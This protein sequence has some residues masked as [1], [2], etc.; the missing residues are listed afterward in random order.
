LSGVCEGVGVCV[1]DLA[2]D[3][4]SPPTIVS[5]AASNQADVNLCHSNSLSVVERFD[6]GEEVG[7]LLNEIG[8]VD[9]QL[10]AVLWG[11]LSPDCP[12]CLSGS[13]YRDIDI[14]LC[15][16]V[17]GCDNLLGGWVDRLEGLAVDTLNKLVV[18]EPVQGRLS[19]VLPRHSGMRGNNVGETYNPVGCSYLPVDGVE[20]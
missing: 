20:S 19:A 13:G 6:S 4:V 12:V 10:A 17:D 3:L 7:I 15:G 9:Q 1:D 11:L 2:L 18:D 14:L 8:E 5:Q 16:L